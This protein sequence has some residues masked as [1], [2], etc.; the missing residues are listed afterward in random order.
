[1][2]KYYIHL[3]FLCLLWFSACTPI[4]DGN[5]PVTCDNQTASFSLQLNWAGAYYNCTRGTF[6]TMQPPYATY[7]NYTATASTTTLQDNMDTYFCQISVK[8]DQPSENPSN[9]CT[10][11]GLLSYTWNSPGGALSIQSYKNHNTDI[12]VDYY[13]ECGP[14]SDAIVEARPYFIGVATIPQGVSGAVIS[15]QTQ[16]PFVGS[17]GHTCSN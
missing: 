13:D 12:T 1:M 15:M 2:K 11:A 17:N 6:G 10:N 8:N 7:T 3:L 5:P 4:I 16:A 9:A 14:C